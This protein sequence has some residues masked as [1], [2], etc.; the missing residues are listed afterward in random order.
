MYYLLH[1]TPKSLSII[2][3][4]SYFSLMHLLMSS[5]TL[6]AGMNGTPSTP[7]TWQNLMC[8]IQNF[9]LVFQV[10]MSCCRCGRYVLNTGLQ[11]EFFFINLY[12][13]SCLLFILEPSF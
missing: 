3:A 7:L 1:I 9:K 8:K 12:L 6:Q 10:K 5:F 4:T 11:I 2:G 13:F